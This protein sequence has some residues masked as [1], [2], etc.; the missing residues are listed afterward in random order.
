MTLHYLAGELSLRLAVLRDGAPDAALPALD[1]LRHE[2]ETKPPSELASVVN[3]A[4]AL[5]NALCWGF[6]AR[7]DLAGFD[8]E[9]SVA[10]DLY[11]FSTC[12]GLTS[13]NRR[14]SPAE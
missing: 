9:A 11:E 6:V 2:A 3:R 4:I 13:E 7:G 5:A 14:R 8:L 12:A 1:L 10:A